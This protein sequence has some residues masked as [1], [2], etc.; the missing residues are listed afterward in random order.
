MKIF[1]SFNLVSFSWIFFRANSFNDAIILI[2]DIL[3]NFSFSIADIKAPIGFSGFLLC[4]SFILFL[5]L[6]HFLDEKDYMKNIFKKVKY[7]E[8]I[9]YYGLILIVLVFGEMGASEQFIYFQFSFIYIYT[10]QKIVNIY[11]LNTNITR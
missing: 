5:E 7:S 6:I 9:F 2:K 8:A 11:K 4:I 3:F 1:I 10:F